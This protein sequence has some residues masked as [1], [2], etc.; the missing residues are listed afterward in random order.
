MSCI[1]RHAKTLKVPPPER[2]SFK[3]YQNIQNLSLWYFPQSACISRHIK[4]SK[5]LQEHTSMQSYPTPL[6]GIF[7]STFHSTQFQGEFQNQ[8]NQT[9]ERRTTQ[10]QGI[11]RSIKTFKIF[12]RTHKHTSAQAGQGVHPIAGVI[13]QRTPTH[14]AK[15]PLIKISASLPPECLYFKAYQ[16]IQNLRLWYFPPERL[17]FKAYQ[18]LSKSIPQK[19]VFQ[20]ISRSIKTFKIFQCRSTHK[21]T[22]VSHPIAGALSTLLSTLPNSKRCFS[23]PLERLYFKAYQNIQNLCVTT[24]SACILGISKHSK[25]LAMVLSSERLY[26]KAYQNIQNLCITTPS[27]FC[28]SGMLACHGSRR[29]VP[30]QQA[31]AGCGPIGGW[32]FSTNQELTGSAAWKCQQCC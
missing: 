28:P 7:H 4:T 30:S 2:L 23:A 9:W 27:P 3:A 11:S 6:Q 16:N 21:H 24:P 17:Y 20:G 19:P 15:P 8:K 13:S 12:Q 14:P 26:F 10:F 32:G 31:L 25:S 1:S 5:T 29:C 22:I 18:N